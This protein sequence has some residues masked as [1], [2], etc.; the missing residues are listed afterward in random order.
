MLSSVQKNSFGSWIRRWLLKLFT[1]LRLFSH[2]SLSFALPSIRSFQTFGIHSWLRAVRNQG[3]L[4]GMCRICPR[5]YLR[6]P[7]RNVLPEKTSFAKNCIL[8]LYLSVRIVFPYLDATSKAPSVQ[9]L[10]GGQPWR[11]QSS[12]WKSGSSFASRKGRA[13]R[14]Q[15]RDSWKWTTPKI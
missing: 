10:P 12:L 14:Y 4:P 7:F 2:F 3:M 5:G 6:H 9:Y 13:R 11:I 1:L 15:K 8:F